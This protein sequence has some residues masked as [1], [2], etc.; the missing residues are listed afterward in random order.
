MIKLV[1]HRGWPLQ[2][3]KEIELNCAIITADSLNDDLWEA[4][5]KGDVSKI[6]HLLYVRKLD[7]NVIDR[8]RRLSE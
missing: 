8:V 6:E 5:R 7:V 2:L 4:A 3:V 1:R